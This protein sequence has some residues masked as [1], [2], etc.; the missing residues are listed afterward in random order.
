MK[1]IERIF[2][3]KLRN[4]VELD[5]MQMGFMPGRGTTDAII[6]MRQY[7]KK[8]EVAR[9]NLYMVVVDLEK[10][11][12]CVPREVIWWSLRRKRLL[13]REI[14]AIM[15]MYTNIETYVKMDCT[16]S[17]PFDVKVGVHQGL[18]LSS[19]LLAIMMDEVAQDIKKGV[20]KKMRYSDDLVLLGDNWKEVESRSLDG[21][22]HYKTKE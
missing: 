8:Y 15:E 10:P 1:V 20:V 2:E 9:R 17:E 19:L 4:D 7:E 13:K 6:I 12:D 18:I 21:K 11:F 22:K 14:K 16:R 5:K 3:S